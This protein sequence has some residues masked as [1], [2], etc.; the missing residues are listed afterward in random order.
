MSSDLGRIVPVDVRQVWPHEARDFTTW[1]LQNADALGDA[2]GLDLELTEAERRIGEF[3]L[4]LIG[5]DGHGRTVIVENQLAQSDHGHLGQILTYAG[6][7]DPQVI[8]WVAPKFREDHRSAVDW[9]NERTD[10]DTNFF[11]IEVSAVRIDDS[12]PAP[13]F[14]L[15]AQP[16]SWTKQVHAQ[17]VDALSGKKAAYADFW[18]RLLERV[19]A[20]FPG[21]TRVRSGGS[22]SWLALPYGRSGIH[23]G[24]VFARGGPRVELYIDTGDAKTNLAE[25]DV[26]A[27]RRSRLEEAFGGPMAFDPL[28]NRR[29]CRIH[30]DRPAGGDILQSDQHEH[31][32]EWFLETAGHFKAAIEQVRQEVE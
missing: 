9:L 25:F 2:M 24:L 17:K 3:T 5:Q 21:W 14:R 31:Y 10:E 27:S 8:V 22:D 7:A 20:A 1:L 18:P 6:G 28:E 26:F 4:D 30:V 16:N 29:A 32:L 23:Y 19:H 11:A 13:L 12:R 15:V